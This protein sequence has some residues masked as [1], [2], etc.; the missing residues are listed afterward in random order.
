MSSCQWWASPEL[1]VT[2]STPREQKKKARDTGSQ[3]C[4]QRQAAG[5]LGGGR[6]MAGIAKGW[7]STVTRV[8][9]L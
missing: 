4:R 2:Q 9:G 7:K 1:L 3:S 5:G 8:R 6:R